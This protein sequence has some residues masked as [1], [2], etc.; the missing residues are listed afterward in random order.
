M[1]RTPQ[2]RKGK[3]TSARILETATGLFAE[4]GFEGTSVD[5]IVNRTGVNKRMVYHY[6]G[7]KLELYRQVLLAAYE[8]IGRFEAERLEGVS[9]FGELVERLVEIGFAFHR[10]HPEFTRLILWENLNEGRGIRTS[11]QHLSK[12]ASIVRI[13][14]ALEAAP[15]GRYRRDLDPRLIYLTIV[16]LTQ[17]YVSNRYTLSQ[18]LNL[19]LASPAVL[20]MGRRHAVQVIHAWLGQPPADPRR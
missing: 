16:G 12:E 14:R 11:P 1:A 10:E 2:I 17:T 6:F 13:R 4:K 7:S 3:P 19:D 8:E 5:A 15:A 20:K 18:G 9:E